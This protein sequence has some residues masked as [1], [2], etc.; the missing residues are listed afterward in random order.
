M[1][2]DHGVRCKGDQ[3]LIVRLRIEQM[4]RTVCPLS[5]VRL[6]VFDNLADHNLKR[7]LDARL[8]ITINC[9]DPAYLDGYLS[10]NFIE[11]QRA[12]AL[13]ETDLVALAK[14][15]FTAN[16]L[17]GEAKSGHHAAVEVAYR[18]FQESDGRPK[19]A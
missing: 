9:D 11:T 4:A 7:L 6:R 18:A 1:R 3:D 5:N 19:I 17:S 15:R 14:N 13:D 16:V 8:L 10:T 2:I 12:L